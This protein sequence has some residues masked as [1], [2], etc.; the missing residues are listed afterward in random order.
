[1]VGQALQQTQQ[2]R[3]LMTLSPLQIRYFKM[4]EMN[5]VQ[6][7]E[8]VRR[9]LDENPALEAVDNSVEESQFNETA[10]ELQR[11]DYRD[12]DDI[13]FYRLEVNNRSADDAWYT[14]EAVALSATLSEHLA[15]ELDMIEGVSQPTVNVAKYVAG[16]LD[17]NGYM[18]R[19]SADMIDDLAI[20]SGV[21][22]TSE[23]MKAAV[24]LVRSLDP[25]GVGAVDLR[26]CLLLQ[27][28]RMS[29][30]PASTLAREI[31]AHYFD[32]F[33]HKHYDRLRSALGVGQDDM[34]D[35]IECIRGLNPKPGSLVETV[36]ANDR[37][38][39]VTPDFVVETDGE[40][41]VT[42]SVVSTIPELQ[43]EAT[44]AAD[45]GSGSAKNPS[46]DAFIRK[47]RDEATGFINI[48]KLR[49]DT[50]MK[51]MAAIVR[52]Q[53]KFFTSGI[54]SDLRP[55]ILRDISGLTGLDASVVSR[56]TSGKYVMTPWGVYPLKFFFNER[57][58]H[59]ED[60]GETSSREIMARLRELIEG[61]DRHH[62]LADRELADL[63]EKDGHRVAR[64][65]VAK[66]R[67]MLGF[68][69]ARLRRDL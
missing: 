6:A 30:T 64:R 5:R 42:A 24:D 34:R 56:A 22:V 13:P 53:H 57:F 62:P 69:V 18:T 40:G 54:E 36:D 33:S 15:G 48:V 55:M 60:D 19:S 63:L 1:M 44:F 43:V 16:N 65:T 20:S 39:H 26:D 38:R 21:T 50:L 9:A 10:E 31:V 32:L 3:Q 27:L 67:E 47:Q 37:L 35:A 7:E 51:V 29:A 28:N 66:Y 52:I 49:N 59:D 25:A 12:E 68:P 14:P 58:S 2:Q 8:E 11:A 41:N 17:A 61:E 45:A 23:Q 46:A 4:L